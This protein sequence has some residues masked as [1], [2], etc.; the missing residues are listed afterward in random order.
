[1]EQQTFCRLFHTLFYISQLELAILH[2]AGIEQQIP[3]FPRYLHGNDNCSVHYLYLDGVSKIALRE[4]HG[5]RCVLY[6]VLCLGKHCHSNTDS[7][8]MNQ[9]VFIIV[10]LG[11]K[12]FHKIGFVAYR[13]HN[14]DA[15]C[16]QC[17]D[18][19]LFHNERLI[20]SFQSNDLFQTVHSK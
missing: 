17:G 6:Q 12:C 10:S 8:I 5:Y 7:Q 14:A 18:D 15:W 13:S 16:E 3:G 20:C 9:L 4:T 19:G 1:M 11:I 2:R